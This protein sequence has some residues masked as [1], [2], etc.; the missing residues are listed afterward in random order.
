M[1]A[2]TTDAPRRPGPKLPEL[3]LTGDERATLERWAR[4]RDSSQALALPCRIVLACAEAQQ[5]GGRRP[6][7]RLQ[8]D[9]DQVALAVCRPPAGGL[10]DEPRPGAA[11]AITDEQVERVL[12]MT[13]RPPQGRNPWSTRSLAAH[14]GMSPSAISRIW[15]AVGLKHLVDTFKLSR[16]PQ[17]LDKVRD[18]VGL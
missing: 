3:A 2:T 11:R 10:A 18:L 14:I 15:R 9:G 16:D 17:L 7:E 1:L 8:A 13:W 4:G 6:A 5:P 12:V